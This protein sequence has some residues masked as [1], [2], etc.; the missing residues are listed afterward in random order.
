MRFADDFVAGFEHREEAE[1]FLAE[2]RERFARFGLQLHADKTRIVEFGRSAEQN[3]R[4][5]SD[6]KPETFNFL[7][8][9]AG[10]PSSLN[11]RRAEIGCGQG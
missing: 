9:P 10:V 1:R 2:L 3:R 11:G 4:N 6:G 5:R 7:G 8:F